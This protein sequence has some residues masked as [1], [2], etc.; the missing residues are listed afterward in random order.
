MNLQF[1][2]I[3]DLIS[4]SSIIINQNFIVGSR[5]NLRRSVLQWTESELS[6]YERST[7]IKLINIV[8]DARGIM[9]YSMVLNRRDTSNLGIIRHELELEL[10]HLPNE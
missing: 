7:W 4:D 2:L 1:L 3:S 5:D 6:T 8:T 10:L 9:L